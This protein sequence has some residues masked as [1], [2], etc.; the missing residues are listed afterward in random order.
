MSSGSRF[1]RRSAA[2]ALAIFVAAAGSSATG[3]AATEADST[4]EA[5]S[6]AV[7]SV[8]GLGDVP[9]RRGDILVAQ[10]AQYDSG[11][12]LVL[13]LRVAR[14]TNPYRHRLWQRGVSQ[15]VW[16]LDTTRPGADWT[17]QVRTTA[18]H[19]H[20]TAAVFDRDGR[21]VCTATA[22]FPAAQDYR[23]TVPA[24]CV[25]LVWRLRGQLLWDRLLTT[26]GPDSIDRAP[27]AG[28]L[29][30]WA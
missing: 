1:I 16:L 11:G 28:W 29:P 27:N 24:S 26:R 7:R 8:D 18:A 25:D 12:T 30:L 3:S 14:P 21:R 19:G 10:A 6:R 4:V 20:F 13:D 9:Y 22:T 5:A 17:L 2:V 15:I 23:V